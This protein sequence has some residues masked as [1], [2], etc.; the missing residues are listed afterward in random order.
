LFLELCKGSSAGPAKYATDI[1]EKLWLKDYNQYRNLSRHCD[2]RQILHTSYNKND[3]Y[4]K[5]HLSTGSSTQAHR[6]LEW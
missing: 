3:I 2:H 6:A 4:K 1:N 5:V